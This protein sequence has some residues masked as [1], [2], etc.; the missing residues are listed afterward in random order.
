[1]A[2]GTDLNE[3]GQ[4]D[5]IAVKPPGKCDQPEGYDLE[6]TGWQKLEDEAEGCGH[7]LIVEARF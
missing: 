7:Y 2:R 4:P 1:M 5:G 3:L 6:I